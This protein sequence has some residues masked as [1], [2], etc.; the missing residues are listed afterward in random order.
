MGDGMA[1][2]RIALIG[3]GLIGR[4]HARFILAHAGA[5]LAGIADIGPAAEAFAA[6]CG[7]PLFADYRA[8]LDATRPDGAIVA[9][10]NALHLQAGLAVIARNIPLFMEKPVADT[11]AAARQLVSAAE[12]AGVPIQVG[13]H[14]RHAP[15][16]ARAKQAIAGGDI[17]RILA[18]NGMWMA[19]KPLDYF[20]VE[21]RRQPGGGPL[22]INLIH[23]VDLLR[24]LCGDVESVMAMTAN[25]ARGFSVEDT[26]VVLLRFVSGALGTF[27][28]SDAVPSPYGWDTAACQALYLA[29][30]PGD[31]FFIGGEKA[32]LSVPSMDLWTHENDGDWRHPLTRKHL[33]HDH[34]SCYVRQLDNFLAVTRGEARPLIDGAD[35][36]RTL[37]TVEAIERA[38]R[39][40][41]RVEIAPILAEA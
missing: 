25:T 26:A 24:H 11:V 9:L 19:K 21:W 41:T 34:S 33:A 4:E 8:L 16:I 38:A 22:L 23:D 10:P 31:C 17:G 6:E 2:Q 3:A 20:N 37:A 18:V 12:A 1:R 14:R 40:D 27:T 39:L 13:H 36:T 32:T 30:Q 5:E 28:L 29:H 35:G 15:D 7:V